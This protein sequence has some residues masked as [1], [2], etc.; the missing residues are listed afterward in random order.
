MA[1]ESGLIRNRRY[2]VWDAEKASLNKLLLLYSSNTECSTQNATL[3]TTYERLHTQND[4]TTGN[5]EFLESCPVTVVDA[6]SEIGTA[7]ISAA[8]SLDELLS[9]ITTS[10]VPKFCYQSVYCCIRY[11]LVRIRTIWRTAAND[12]D[13]NIRQWTHVRG[14]PMFAHLHNFWATGVNRGLAAR[15]TLTGAMGEA[16]G[17]FTRGW[18]CLWLHFC[19]VERVCWWVA[20]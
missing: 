12:L 14:Y 6:L 7:V 16:D 19:T 17:V 4:E 3:T 1:D 11:F 5:F 2:I 10:R 8:L 20:I 18:T 15:M 13:T 9:Q